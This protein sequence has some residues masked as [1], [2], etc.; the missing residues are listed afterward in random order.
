MTLQGLFE[1]RLSGH[2][3]SRIPWW[4]RLSWGWSLTA[5][6]WTLMTKTV[7]LHCHKPCTSGSRRDGGRQHCAL[8]ILFSFESSNSFQFT[9]SQLSP[10]QKFSGSCMN[11][12]KTMQIKLAGEKQLESAPYASAVVSLGERDGRQEHH[13][14]SGLSAGLPPPR[15]SMCWFPFR[16][17]PFQFLPKVKPVDAQTS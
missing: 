8:L 10:T 3:E 4:I 1:S 6:S 15:F 5:S 9:Y 17:N 14:P 2:L 11:N 12:P 13:L 7:T 16:C